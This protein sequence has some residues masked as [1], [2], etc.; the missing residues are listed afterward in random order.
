MKKQDALNFL[1]SHKQLFI[2]QFGVKH[3]ALIIFR[4]ARQEYVAR[5]LRFPYTSSQQ[6][7]P[8]LS[9]M[10][11]RGVTFS[12]FA[13]HAEPTATPTIPLDDAYFGGSFVPGACP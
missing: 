2:E 10:R 8:R 6:H 9:T 11:T 7:P 1:E 5:N 13:F 3:L 12:G 4:H